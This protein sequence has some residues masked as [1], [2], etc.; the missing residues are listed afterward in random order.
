[1]S[2][3]I[4]PN[5]KMMPFQGYTG[6]GGGATGLSMSSGDA[7]GPGSATGDGTYGNPSFSPKALKATGQT[8]QGNYWFSP[9]GWP[10][11]RPPQELAYWVSSDTD[12]GYVLMAVYDEESGFTQSDGNAAWGTGGTSEGKSPTTVKDYFNAIPTDSTCRYIGR[13]FWNQMFHQGANNNNTYTE[14]RMLSICPNGSNAGVIVN[15]YEA[16]PGYKIT[17]TNAFELVYATGSMNNNWDTRYDT[18]ATNTTNAWQSFS[19]SSWAT[20]NSGRSGSPGDYH[21][22]PDDF[23]TSNQWMFREN[24]DDTS[25][26]GNPNCSN[27]PSMIFC[28]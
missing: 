8:T 22:I 11:A 23:T 14:Y 1:M 10:A 24:N 20:F 21:Y 2:F 16:K 3:L 4:Y 7:W 13:D 25:R 26:E 12:R 9:N 27:A 15:E 17:S 6:F 19:L 5:P 28:S 18:L